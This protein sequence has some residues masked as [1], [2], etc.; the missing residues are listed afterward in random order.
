MAVFSFRPSLSYRGRKF[1][2]VRG[3]AG[4]PFHPPLTDI[5]VGAYTIA[6][7]FDVISRLGHHYLWSYDFFRAATFVFVAGAVVSVFTALTGIWDW[8]KSTTKGTQARRTANAH[9]ITMITV[10]V[11]VA[12][13]IYLRLGKYQHLNFTPGRLTIL[14]LVIAGLVTLGG[15]I[16]GTLVY[17]YGFNVETATDSAVWHK[18]DKDLFPKDKAQAAN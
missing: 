9:G 1:K 3:F 7:A 2:V 16:G 18:S 11:L 8:W 14:G 12:L 15:T 10:T 17:D 13:D 5:P 6:P 4:K